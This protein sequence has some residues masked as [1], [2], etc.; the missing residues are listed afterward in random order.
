MFSNDKWNTDKSYYFDTADTKVHPGAS[1]GGSHG[2][3]V[4][5][6]LSFLAMKV[7]SFLTFSSYL[8]SSKCKNSFNSRRE[9]L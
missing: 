1:T 2:E 6:F 4:P 3:G 8:L 7:P 5:I 9:T